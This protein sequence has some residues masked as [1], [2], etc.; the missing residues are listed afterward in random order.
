MEK[1]HYFIFTE[2]VAKGNRSQLLSCFCEYTLSSS[3]DT[4]TVCLCS[5]FERQTSISSLYVNHLR[6]RRIQILIS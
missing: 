1:N 2:D 4:S 6:S 5:V 3:F